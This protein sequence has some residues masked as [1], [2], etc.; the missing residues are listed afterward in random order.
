MFGMY[1]APIAVVFAILL[2]IVSM[3]LYYTDEDVKKE[4]QEEREAKERE[5]G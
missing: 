2:T 3:I 5:N 4:K 1:K